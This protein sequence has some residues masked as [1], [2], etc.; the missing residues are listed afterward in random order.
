MRIPRIYEPALTARSQAVELGDAAARHVVKVL[1]LA[2]GAPL[3]LFDGQGHAF[4]ARL[5][6][7]KP[8]R[9]LLEDDVESAPEPPLKIELLQALSR[10]AKMD[11]VVQKAVELGAAGIVPVVTERSIMRL[12]ARAA[13]KK[14]THWQS[15]VISA[16][17]Q[18]GRDRLP[19]V[20]APA[21]FADALES[22]DANALQ[23]LLDPDAA[24]GLADTAAPSCVRLLIGPEGGLTDA[25]RDAAIRQGFV[26]VKLGPRVMRTETAALAALAAIQQR[27][28]D[29]R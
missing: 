15:I 1:R 6:S 16:C 2:P 8:V 9:A 24:G 3:I 29:F 13:E 18:C 5:E 12:D 20:A 19:A 14:R 25:E 26:P 23:L 22:G 21:T 11:L 17:E 4:S 7:V 10:G 27:W 28:G